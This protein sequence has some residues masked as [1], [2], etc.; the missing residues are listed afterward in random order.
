MYDVHKG[1]GYGVRGAGKKNRE[2]PSNSVWLKK[3]LQFCCFNQGRV[4]A[5]GSSGRYLE[6]YCFKVRP[7][8]ISWIIVFSSCT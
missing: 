1:M 6:I 3:V 2:T 8:V 5:L 4:P 7:S